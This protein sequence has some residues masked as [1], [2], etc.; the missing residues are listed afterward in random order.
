MQ[1]YPSD[2]SAVIIAPSL[3][4]LDDFEAEPAPERLLD[5]AP[6]GHPSTRPPTSLSRG[7]SRQARHR[8]QSRLERLV[9]IVRDRF[10]KK[11]VRTTSA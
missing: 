5:V 3:G 9:A 1:A 8:R 10:V 7:E 4:S 2:G 11:T 6:A